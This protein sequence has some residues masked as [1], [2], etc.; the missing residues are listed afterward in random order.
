MWIVNRMSSVKNGDIVVPGDQLCVIEEMSPSFGTYEKD[1]VVFATTAGGV[2]IDL[3]ARSI[4][5]LGPDGSNKLALPVKG[6]ILIG[7]VIHAYESRAEISIVKR[8]GKDILSSLQGE[9]RIGTVTR[10][11][12]K[13]MHD[14]IRAGDVIRAVALNTHEIPVELSVV[15]PDLGVIL[16]KCARCG[17]DL[18]LTTHNNMVCLRCENHETREAAKDYGV[19]FGLE[20][21][22]DIAPRRR[23][24]GDR[25]GED[26]R[27]G[28]RRGGD[29]RG[30]DSRRRSGDRRN[31]RRDGDRR[32]RRR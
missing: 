15:G 10:R 1:G 21:R 31:S 26:R 18:V 29:R 23:S 7:E 28:D 4:S 2:S 6:D 8:N 9:I 24:Y 20:A 25:R 14:A 12:V 11:F 5:V 13:S 16:G 30:R 17:N 3:K 22:P 27:Y 19:M 32:P